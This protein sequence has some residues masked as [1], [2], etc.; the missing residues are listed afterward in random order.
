MDG[1]GHRKEQGE[2]DGVCSVW[3]RVRGASLLG[4]KMKE[5]MKGVLL[6]FGAGCTWV[7]LTVTSVFVWGLFVLKFHIPVT[8][9]EG[10]GWG[11]V[12]WGMGGYITYMLWVVGNEHKTYKM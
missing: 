6:G 4:G 1:L 2:R 11:L 7:G 3:K 8:K 9:F 5:F 12:F 10:F